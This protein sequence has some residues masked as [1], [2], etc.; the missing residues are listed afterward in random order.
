[1][2]AIYSPLI[3]KLWMQ[4]FLF[5]L[6]FIQLRNIGSKFNLIF[7]HFKT[8]RVKMRRLINLIPK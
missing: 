7:P 1:M 8:F 4:L 3:I 5:E 6:F 2:E